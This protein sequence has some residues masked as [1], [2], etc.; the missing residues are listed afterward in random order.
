MQHAMAT[1]TLS[2]E[3]YRIKKSLGIVR[4]ITVR[5]RSFIGSWAASVQTI[6]GGNITILFLP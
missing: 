6:F 3:G 5:S 2:L 4:G 1:T